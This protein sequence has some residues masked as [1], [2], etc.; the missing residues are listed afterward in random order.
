MRGCTTITFAIS[1]TIVSLFCFFYKIENANKNETCI[2]FK[3][4]TVEYH[5]N[6]KLLTRLIQSE[7]GTENFIDK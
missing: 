1:L 4:T 3:P 2:I 5:E 6:L 7:S